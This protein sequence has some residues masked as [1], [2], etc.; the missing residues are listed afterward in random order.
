[1]LYCKYLSVYVSKLVYLFLD[2]HKC[3]DQA[4]LIVLHVIFLPLKIQLFFF[5][6]RGYI[7][8]PVCIYKFMYINT[9]A[10]F[11]GLLRQ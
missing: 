6:Y 2:A 4:L 10:H 11:H 3:E 8:M 9:K 7:H 5:I 1:M